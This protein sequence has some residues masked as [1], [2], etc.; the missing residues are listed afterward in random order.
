MI[1][2]SYLKGKLNSGGGCEA[3]VT[4]RLRIGW[5]RFKEYRE[6]LLGNKFPLKIKEKVYHCCLRSAML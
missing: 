1:G 2:Y 6:L 5:V 4:T 3:A